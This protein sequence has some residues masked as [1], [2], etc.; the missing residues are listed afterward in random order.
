MALLYLTRFLF[1]LFL[2]LFIRGHVSPVRTQDWIDSSSAS[3]MEGD[4]ECFSE[5]MEL[6]VHRMRIE[7]LRLW[8]SAM[9][10][11]QVTLASLE[12]LNHQLSACGFGLH[13]DP[14]RNYIFRVMYSGCFLQVEH[15]HYVMVLNLLKRISRFGGRTRNYVMKCPVVTAL[16]NREHI[17]CDPDFIQVTRQIPV[18]SWNNELSWSLVLRGSLVVALEDASLI[19]VHVDVHKPHITVQGRRN[20]ILSPVQVLQSE[21]QFLPLKLVSGNYA[22]SMEATCP[23][24]TQYSSENTILYIYKRRM[25]LTKRGGYDNETLSVSSVSV[26]QTS[27]FSWSENSGF[28]KL[29]IPTA[30]IQKTKKC[31]DKESNDLRQAFFR[32]D[33]VLAFKETNNKMAWTME[34]TSP[35]LGASIP[36]LATESYPSVTP[37]PR[38]TFAE[39]HMTSVT[40][41]TP[42]YAEATHHLLLS[43]GA[44]SMAPQLLSLTTEGFS[45]T[46]KPRQMFPYTQGLRDPTVSP[47][48]TGLLQTDTLQVLNSPDSLLANREKS[49]ER[50][51]EMAGTASWAW[52]TSSAAHLNAHGVSRFVPTTS[53]SFTHKG[54]TDS[55]AAPWPGSHVSSLNTR[56]TSSLVSTE[57]S[58]LI[59]DIRISTGVDAHISK[60]A[61]PGATP[62]HYGNV[63]AID[64]WNLVTSPSPLENSSLSPLELKEIDNSKE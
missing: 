56:E 60:T 41:A 22:Y 35:C 25:G 15:G 13:K 4:V 17:Q 49:Y 59:A 52:T 39:D 55:N 57:Q 48:S 53:S 8:L 20:T 11:I 34:N 10:R 19:Q 29:I 62:S 7:G 21:G 54:N 58:R 36:S 30:L 43:A 27:A 24:V 32:I 37:K 33:V 38:V 31:T 18:D 40:T 16:P 45:K 44:S 9:L 61:S 23:R 47:W 12:S 6:W 28:V 5:Y 1:S 26:N 64:K 3:T 50:A 42:P 14:D 2:F 63:D 46:F 51:A